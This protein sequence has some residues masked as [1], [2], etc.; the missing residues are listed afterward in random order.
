[1]HYQNEALFRLRLASGFLKEAEQDF[2]LER[3]RSCID[4]A[5]LCSEN[6][7]KSIIAIF[8]PIE[9]T[10]DPSIQLKKLIE[11]Q[12]VDPG[13]FN[14]L[15]RLIPL[16]AKLGTE[17]HFLTDYGDEETLSTPWD[18]YSKDDAAEALDV[19]RQCID[20]ARRIYKFYFGDVV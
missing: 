4:N 13:F 18:I 17:E 14:D 9:K 8:K 3:W 7:G 11:E 12:V 20:A 16:Y 15:E 6:A 10:H 1:M 2:N 5:Q 19:A